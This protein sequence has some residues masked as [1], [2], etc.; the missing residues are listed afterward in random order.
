MN[1]S[2]SRATDDINLDEFERRLRAAGA[3]QASAEDPLV[4]LARL[5]E[6]SRFG[7]SDRATSAEP[8]AEPARR[9][10]KSAPP[11]ETEALR[12][13]IDEAE[14]FV[15]AASEA[16]RDARQDYEFPTHPPHDA[17]AAEQ[18]AAERPKALEAQGFRAGAGGR[19][20]DRRGVGAQGR[21]AGSVRNSRRSSR[22]RKGRPRCSRPATT[23]LRPP[24]TRARLSSRTTQS[25][26]RSKSSVPRSSRSI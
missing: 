2:G 20:D 4:E 7:F 1:V 24:V 12:P 14:D 16:D 11:I 22:R 6:S 26:H 15:P 8:V 10:R 25:R 13:T 18:A 21:G 5:V 17:N 9:T 23:R 19:G 3:Q